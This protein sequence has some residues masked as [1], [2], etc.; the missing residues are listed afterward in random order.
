M[1]TK[2]ECL[3]KQQ[4]FRYN[5]IDA[6]K[7]MMALCVAA[8]HIRP[9]A[10]GE[11]G[12]FGLM[13]CFDT[14]F[15]LAVPFFFVTT[16]YFIGV[17]LDDGISNKGNLSIIR[18]Y[19]SK[20]V[21]L[22][23][24]WTIVYLPLSLLF[25]KKYFKGTNIRKILDFAIGFLFKGEHWQSYMLWYLLS[26]IYTLAFLYILGRYRISVEK[27]FMI[28]LLIFIGAGLYERK[29]A[30]MTYLFP[31]K[32]VHFLFGSSGRLFTG[33]FYV[34]LGMML[35]RKNIKIQAGAAMFLAGF[36]GYALFE[37]GGGTYASV[38]LGIGAAGLFR[39]VQSVKVKDS[40]IYA[41]CRMASKTVYFCHLMIHT[42]LSL[43]LW[44]ELRYGLL[45]F[46]SVIL[47][48]AGLSALVFYKKQWEPA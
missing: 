18:Q 31:V 29:I 19:L 30:G 28:S 43:I 48:N 41:F 2:Y 16:G 46:M 23:V 39:C 20:S 1:D 7:L 33:P 15:Q 8:I 37:T 25:Y 5:S 13:R 10:V 45:V 42:I 12:Q 17:K 3:K 35:S 32:A 22:Y 9:Y 40:E 6:M 38:F 26:L 44:N 36:L 24:I 11:A 21:R 4:L 34:S 14:F 27:I 47:I